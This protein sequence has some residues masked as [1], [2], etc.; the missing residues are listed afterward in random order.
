M[1]REGNTVSI[2]G[3]RDE[4]M[5]IIEEFLREEL[6]P[7][8]ASEINKL[9]RAER[10]RLSAKPQERRIKRA[11]VF[12]KLFKLSGRDLRLI[13]LGMVGGQEQGVNANNISGEGAFRE[14]DA[15]GGASGTD[16]EYVTRMRAKSIVSTKPTEMRE[17]QD[18]DSGGELVR[19]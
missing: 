17:I 11:S 2:K 5:K 12:T 8:W 15:G 1:L 16:Q 3:L 9:S 19:P 13:K 4:K 7:D 6:G 18:V 10:L 14:A